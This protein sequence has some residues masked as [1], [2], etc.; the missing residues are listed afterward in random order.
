[1]QAH[2]FLRLLK[3]D[4]SSISL[5]QLAKM[6]QITFLV[7]LENINGYLMDHF[8]CGIR[9]FTM[10]IKTAGRTKIK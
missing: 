5:C 6:A 9:K 1:M 7:L 8:A 4:G 2:S 3:L 10:Q